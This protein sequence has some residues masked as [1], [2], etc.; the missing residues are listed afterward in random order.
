MSFFIKK[1]LRE[2]LLNERLTDVDSDVDLIYQKFF[3]YDI[4]RLNKTGK[5]DGNMF[6]RT[7]VDTSILTSPDS[8]KAH[9][10]NPCDL[11]INYGSNFYHPERSLISVSVIGQAIDYV[12]SDYGGDLNRAIAS[13]SDIKTVKY[14]KSDFSEERIKGSIHHEL[15]HWIDDTL[16]NRHLSKTLN[17]AKE[18]KTKD[19]KGV[20]FDTHYIELQAQ[21]HN[22]KQLYNKYKDI[23]NDLSFTD[24]LE[25]SSP[26]FGLY[27][28]FKPDVRDKW[29]LAIKKRMAREGILGKKMY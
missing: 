12:L 28:R 11:A 6:L 3:E 8:V 26:L 5:I 4:E 13:L 1:L 15:V 25:F 23:W 7:I 18:L 9:E 27:N 16:N 2:N 17:K 22:I 19:F 29:V 14:I 21:I 24:M 10:I 20:P